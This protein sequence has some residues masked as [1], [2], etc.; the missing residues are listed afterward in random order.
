MELTKNDSGV[1]FMEGRFDL[2]YRF[3]RISRKGAKKL[4]SLFP[5]RQ[6]A[7]SAQETCSAAFVGRGGKPRGQ[8]NNRQQEIT[9]TKLILSAALVAAAFLASSTDAHAQV[10]VASTYRPALVRPVPAPV[11]T[12]RVATPNFSFNYGSPYRAYNYN[13]YPVYP[14]SAYNPYAYTYPSYYPSVLPSYYPSVAPV[15]SPY[16]VPNVS[17]N[18]GSYYPY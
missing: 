7:N 1:E 6:A 9:M 15:Y 13:A 2:S 12:I 4:P 5:W 8:K 14:Y 17:Y 10:R 16:V 18:Y 11:T 3:L